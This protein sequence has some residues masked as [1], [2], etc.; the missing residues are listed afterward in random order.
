MLIVAGN[1]GVFSLADDGRTG[2]SFFAGEQVFA[3]A[4]HG[5]RVAVAILKKGVRLSEDGG[6]SW[7]DISAGLP[8][9]DVRSLAFDPHQPE[10]LYAGTEPPAIACHRG[11]EW[12]LCGN[13]MALPESKDWS[14]PVRPGIPHVR[15]ITVSPVD[16]HVI[17]AAIEVGSFLISR[18]T[19]MT[20]SVAEG[21][22]HDLHRTI[23]HPAKP[24]RLLVATG[25]DT[26]AYRGG[27]GVYRSEDGGSTW[28]SA[29][30]GL[31]HRLYAEDA[32]AFH[33]QD[34]ATA[35]LAA[36]DG[37]PPHWA[38]IIGL[39]TGVMSGNVYFLS[40]SKFRRRK[41]ADIAIYRTR[42]VGKN[43]AL[44]PDINQQGLFDMV[45]ALESGYAD[46]GSP[47]VYFA[48]TGGEVRASYD[49][50]D[51]WRVIAK[52]M[53]AITHLHPLH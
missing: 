11:A 39:A 44:V 30:E 10:R 22:G 19:G 43:W 24:D 49:G 29:N 50:G 38:S 28:S 2:P 9:L 46:D 3:L 42:D 14:F 21:I 36:A 4:A 27:K 7:R 45:W 35:F 18:D 53:G 40:P 34:P 17:Y 32:I 13:L 12:S 8:Y 6:V 37:I 1:K 48:T 5:Q 31:G 16:S 25:M 41:G 15:S 20:W 33:P 47:A 51:T 52:E 26:G 23:I